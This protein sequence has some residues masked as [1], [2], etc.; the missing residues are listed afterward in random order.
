MSGHPWPPKP[1]KAAQADVMQDE[2][3]WR[4]YE[5]EVH[6]ELTSKYPNAT[7]DFDV[8]LPGSRSGTDRQIDILLEEVLPGGRVVTAID[9]KHHARRIDVKQVEAFLGLLQDIQVDRGIMVSALGYTQAAMTRAFRDDVDLD[10]DVFSLADFKQWQAAGAIP[11][12][13][14]NAVLLSAPLGWVVDGANHAGT[15]ARLYRRGLTFEEATRQLEFMYV[16]L[17]DR[18]GSVDSLDAL[19]AKQTT[20]IIGHRPN[21]QL[22]VREMF[23]SS[24]RR[25]CIRRAEIPEYPTAELTGFVEFP[26]SIFFAVLFTPL[27]VERRNVRKLEYILKEV[28]PISVRN[29]A[30]PT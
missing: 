24:G 7:I 9:A 11:Y 5:R 20:D 22:F 1:K 30:R 27:A 28:L 26:Q 3:E 23:S 10:L 18:V 6:A 21:A 12:S 4:K 25:A 13:G 19:L 16:N 17:W 14:R 29:A 8:K 15:I 2:P